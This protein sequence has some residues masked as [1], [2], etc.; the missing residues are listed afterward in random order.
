MMH[1]HGPEEGDGLSCNELLLVDGTRAGACLVR[2]DDEKR[3][4]FIEQLKKTDSPLLER[5]AAG[6][7]W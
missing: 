6:D 2:T 7:D 4:L 1:N 5:L 3:R